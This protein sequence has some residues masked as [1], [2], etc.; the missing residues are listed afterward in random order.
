MQP[1][2]AAIIGCGRIAHR[3]AAGY[4]EDPDHWRVVAVCDSNL[5]TAQRLADRFGECEVMQD[6]Q[7]VLQRDDIDAIDICLPHDLH[8]PVAIAS[9]AAGKHLLIEKPLALDLDEAREIVEAAERAGIV[10]SVGH[11]QRYM[12]QHHQVKAILEQGILG[13]LL[14]ARADLNQDLLIQTE[15]MGGTHHWLH[16]QQAAGGGAIISGSVHKLDLMRWLFGEVARVGSFQ[17]CV[18]GKLQGEDVA[19]TMLEFESGLVAEVV[20][21]YA[22]R[23][24][25]WG[26]MLII[27]GTEGTLHEQWGGSD[28]GIWVHSDSAESWNGGPR[29]DDFVRMEVDLG[30]GIEQE[31]KHWAEC[32]TTEAVPLSSGRDALRTM[33]LVMAIYEAAHHKRIVDVDYSGC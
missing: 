8:K 19:V 6:W 1:L 29:Y 11:N 3:H 2:R 27:H 31:I 7:A 18:S 25:R 28:T 10:L 32:I 23:H 12:P 5:D 30:R 14:V 13:Q 15:K 22:C 20:S 24:A 33:A 16:S 9:A 26:E 4:L 21:L 17:R